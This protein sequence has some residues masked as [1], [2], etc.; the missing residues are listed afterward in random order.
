M[1]LDKRHKLFLVLTGVFITCFVVGDLIGG[2]LIGQ[3]IGGW[4]FYTTVGMLPF[5]VTFLLTDLLN[6]F[7]GK[8]AARFVTL[9]GFFMGVLSFVIVL[10]AA[11]IPFAA[12]TRQPGFDGVTEGSFNSVF[13]GSL[14]MIIASLT[15]Y[16]V[17][18]FV[19]I[20]V[21]HALK[22][23]TSGRL[24]WLRATGSTVVSQLID[25]VVI[26]VVAWSGGSVADKIKNIIVTNYGLK[27]VIAIALTP[28]IYVCHGLVE[29]KLGIPPILV[30]GEA[31][32]DVTAAEAAR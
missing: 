7:Y 6:E 15:A 17:A 14:R 4:G 22:R 8:R 16:L 31:P 32:D 30:G 3:E 24:L 12:F 13:L 9:L 25:T 19:D 11:Q 29:R 2:K 1:F 21:F 28:M 10:A 23:Y 5:P 18:Q 20:G 27:L 26:T